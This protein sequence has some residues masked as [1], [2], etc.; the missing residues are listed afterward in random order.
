VLSA[1]HVRRLLSALDGHR[2]RALVAVAALLGLRRGELIG[3]KWA[4]V[5]LDAR[6]LAVRRTGARIAGEY[7]EGSPKSARSRRTITIPSILVD[8]LRQHRARIHAER[9]R[10]GP[11]WS[12]ENRVFPNECGGPLGATTIRRTLDSATERAGLPHLR[13][14]D[15]RH[16]A[17]TMLIAAGGSL[18]AAQE[19]L[20]HATQSLTADLYAHVLD[21]QRRETADRIDR[22]MR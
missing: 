21:E 14:H 19:L 22:T 9:L 1:D 16:T 7:T 8:E 11:Q 18:S 2:L 13:V 20:G 5:D 6:T 15:L 17:A 12:D 3:L 10:L 4:D